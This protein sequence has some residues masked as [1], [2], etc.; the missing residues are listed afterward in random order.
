MKRALSILENVHGLEHPQVAIALGHLG[1]LY[2]AQG[3]YAEAETLLKRA[4]AIWERALG[5]EHRQVAGTLRRLAKI[6]E[7]EGKYAE[8]EPLLTR[9]LAIVGKDLGPS[10]PGLLTDL[11]NYAILLTSKRYR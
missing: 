3:R 11:D 9:S 8:A 2:G 7:A 10:D 4:L 6:Y 5:P 1:A